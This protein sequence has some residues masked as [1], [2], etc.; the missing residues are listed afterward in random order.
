[1]MQAG[2]G[3][4]AI[5]ATRSR[6]AYIKQK[7]P[8]PGNLSSGNNCPSGLPQVGCQYRLSHG[9]I[10]PL[11]DG[12]RAVKPTFRTDAGP[13]LTPQQTWQMSFNPYHRIGFSYRI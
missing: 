4:F 12:F 6:G 7:R 13:L 9:R 11:I 5:P 2:I 3:V 10:A 8:R 1:M